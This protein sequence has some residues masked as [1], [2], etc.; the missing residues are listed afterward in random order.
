MR[1]KFFS[2]VNCVMRRA[3]AS[4]RAVWRATGSQPGSGSAGTRDHWSREVMVSGL[5]KQTKAF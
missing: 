3:F 2:F 1:L 4:L 5:S